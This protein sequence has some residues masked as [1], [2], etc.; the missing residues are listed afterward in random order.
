MKRVLFFTLLM[1]AVVLA[2]G[3][4]GGRRGGGLRMAGDGA[5]PG[6]GGSGMG[7]MIMAGP[8]SRT[9]VTGA[10]YSAVETRQIQQKLMDG[11]TITRQETT[12]VYRDSQGRVRMEHTATPPGSQTA[13]T[14]ISIFD[15]VGGY[16]Y[17]LNPSG[18]TARKMALPPPRSGGSGDRPM[19]GPRTGDPNA[20]TKSEDLGTQ[21][22]NGQAATGARITTTISAGAMGNAQPIVITRETWVST[23]LKV[24]VQIK[25]SD[26]RFGTTTMNLANI[27]LGEPDPTLFQ[28]P[29]SYSVTTGGRGAGPMMRR[30]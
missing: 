15:P 21:T 8:G 17:M 7:G 11:N 24:P 19:R 26:P 3:P 28:V 9:P 27:V 18:Q 6:M 29:A 16:T 13:E 23:A 5:G 2:Q 4:G 22:V 1:A 20:T 14:R 12:K 25:S 30:K 10:P